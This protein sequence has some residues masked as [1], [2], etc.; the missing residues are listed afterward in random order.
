MTRSPEWIPAGV[1]ISV[2]STAR[3]YDYVL[4]GGHNFAVDRAVGTRIERAT[5]GL[6]DAAR[7]NR[8]FPGRAVRF[9]ADRGIRQL[10]DLGSGI[11]T[12]ANVHEVAR[13]R[14]PRCRVVDVDRDP[15]AVAHGELMFSGNDLVTVVRAD[16][17][18]PEKI[19]SSPEVCGLLDL[20]RPVGLPGRRAVHRVRPRGAGTGRL[21]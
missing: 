16:L 2:P 3:T 6:R 19:L 10:L 7:V 8:A 14:D 21:R 5:P 15:V 4:G 18:D 13:A 20:D 17:R 12:V 9:M 1:D 11:P